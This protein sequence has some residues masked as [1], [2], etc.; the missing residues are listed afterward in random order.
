MTTG[1][2]HFS[3]I[4]REPQHAMR[5]AARPPAAEVTALIAALGLPVPPELH[6]LYA[7]CD[8]SARDEP[9]S[10]HP[11]TPEDG[12]ALLSVAEVAEWKQ[13][14]DG[15]ARDY[16]NQT[17]DERR[18]HFHHGFWSPS[19]IPIAA[20]SVDDLYALATAPCFGGP[21]NQ[22]VAFNYK[23]DTSWYVVAESLDAFLGRLAVL[24]AESAPR[25]ESTS[26][27]IALV[28]GELTPERFDRTEVH[29]AQERV[30]ARALIDRA[31][32]EHGVDAQLLSERVLVAVTSAANEVFGPTRVIEAELD[33]D[34]ADVGLYAVLHVVDQ[35]VSPGR[36]VA[37]AHVAH[38]G[39]ELGD[40]MLVQLF[41]LPSD[42][43]KFEVQDQAMGLALA[44]DADLD[45]ATAA[46][47]E[48]YLQVVADALRSA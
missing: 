2:A 11:I 15:F 17:E 34:A 29:Q 43:A 36:E 45:R 1:L 4:L 37:H 27:P 22:V 9:W 6:Q 47:R 13:L 12:L 39:F 32:V 10:K 35:V 24:L 26:R 48:R 33:G 31:A 41:F 28:I 8:G 16:L 3:T 21:A 30:T 40:Q 20:S 18:D 38:L 19:W 7:L 23:G 5:F 25:F 44:C 42:E 46:W 14:W